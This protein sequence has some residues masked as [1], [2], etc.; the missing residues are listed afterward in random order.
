MNILQIRIGNCLRL[1]GQNLDEFVI[2]SEVNVNDNKI[3]VQDSKGDFI[4]I[5]MNISSG[6]ILPISLS[7]IVLCKLGYI[8]EERAIYGLPP[9]NVYSQYFGD[10]FVEIINDENRG[11]SLVVPSPD[12][13]FACKLK[14]IVHLSDLQNTLSSLFIYKIDLK[15]FE[16]RKNNFYPTIEGIE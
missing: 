13:T 1:T 4:P 8:K 6:F 12:S 9:T 2:V 3:V 10:Y 15:S 11:W 7:E 14:P 16:E 5:D